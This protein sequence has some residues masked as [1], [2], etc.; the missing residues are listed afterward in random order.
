MYTSHLH[1]LFTVVIVCDRQVPDGW[2]EK[3][4]QYQVAPGRNPRE[5]TAPWKSLDVNNPKRRWRQT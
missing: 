2:L 4:E 1:R 3:Q 5:K